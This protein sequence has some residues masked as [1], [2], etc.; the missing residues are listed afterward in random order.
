MALSMEDMNSI[1]AELDDRYVMQS[2]CNEIQANNNKKF[3]Y[4][5]K[6]IEKQE[7]FISGLKKFGWAII[8]V[9]VGEVVISLLTLLK[10]IP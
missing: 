2:E 5:D 8:S 10:D 7:E 1:K 3:A 6:R 9:L 4:D